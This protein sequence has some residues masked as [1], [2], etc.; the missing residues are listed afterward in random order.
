VIDPNSLKVLEL[1]C[2]EKYPNKR[3]VVISFEEKSGN[4][5]ITEGNTI[6]ENLNVPENIILDKSTMNIEFKVTKLNVT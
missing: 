3:N 1:K 2:I 4:F 6:K 5:I